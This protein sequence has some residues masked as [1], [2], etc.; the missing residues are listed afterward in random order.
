M[1]AQAV[2]VSVCSVVQVV[3]EQVEFTLWELCSSCAADDALVAELVA[4]G[5]LEPAG[6]GPDTWCFNGAS[7]AVTRRAQRLIDDL[8]VNAAGA[9]VVIELMER[10]D[11]LERSAGNSDTLSISG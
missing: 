7:L 11:R 8:G 1:N 3:E 4:H 5:L 10:I 2:V 6:A 9:A